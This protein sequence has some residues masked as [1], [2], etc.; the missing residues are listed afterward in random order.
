MVAAVGGAL[1]LLLLL[2]WIAATEVN[3]LRRYRGF[4]AAGET[5]RAGLL[6]V[7]LVTFNVLF[8]AA[9]FNPELSAVGRGATAFGLYA[10][11]MM[12]G[13][14]PAVSRPD[15]LVA[16]VTWS[17]CPPPT[18]TGGRGPGRF[19]ADRPRAR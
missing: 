6:R 14:P 8:A 16:A 3:A 18:G 17:R 15:G 7:L 19:R 1:G 5:E 12:I 13:E 10:L 9:L 11:M 4:V 2:W